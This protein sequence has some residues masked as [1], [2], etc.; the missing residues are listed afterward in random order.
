[1]YRC[2]Y[3][4]QKLYSGFDN[5]CRWNFCSHPTE[6][7]YSIKLCGWHGRTHQNTRTTLFN[8]TSRKIRDW[9]CILYFESLE[10]KWCFTLNTFFKMFKYLSLS[11]FHLYLCFCSSLWMHPINIFLMAEPLCV[12][13]AFFSWKC[14]EF[15]TL[16]EKQRSVLQI[17]LILDSSAPRTGPLES[18]PWA[19]VFVW[20]QWTTRNSC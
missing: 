9:V 15:K 17:L 19:I 4:M 12:M 1:M 6:F 11:G 10:T 14:N 13:F 2:I 8:F 20:E 7:L 5:F 18:Q 16:S 3:I